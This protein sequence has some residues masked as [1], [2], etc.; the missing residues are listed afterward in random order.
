MGKCKINFE[1]FAAKNESTGKD[2][3]QEDKDNNGTDNVTHTTDETTSNVT[4]INVHDLGTVL[5]NIKKMFSYKGE[6]LIVFFYK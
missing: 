2:K 3:P 4:T 5:F 6:E 1:V